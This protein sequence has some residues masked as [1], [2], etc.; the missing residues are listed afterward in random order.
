MF[1]IIIPLYN[2][3][4]TIQRTLKSVFAQNYNNFEVII[5]DDGSTD[6]GVKVITDFTND[7]RLKIFQQKNQGVSSARN[8]GVAFA[9]YPY[10]AFLDG[11]DEWLPE[12][13]E[14]MNVVLDKH[15]SVGMICCAGYVR[16]GQNEYLRLAKKYANKILLV[17]YFENPHVFTHVSATV[18]TKKA[19]DKTEG[20]P[21]GMRKNEDYALLFSVGIVEEVAYC[22]IPLSIYHGG[23]DGQA[24]TINR[25]ADYSVRDV[26]KRFNLC[27]SIFDKSKCR[28]SSLYLTFERYELRHMVIG[29]IRNN[30][31][32]RLKMFL[33]LLNH[34]VLSDFSEME[35]WLWL[36]KD[37][38][39]IAM[40]H[41]YA[42]KAIWRLNGFPVLN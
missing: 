17:D 26:A 11:D 35:V 9:K 42:S 34:L 27:R 41:I 18:I 30:D 10:I 37:M 19:F 14:T 1:S 8:N 31:Y 2:K 6:D 16:D 36:R 12:Y 21:L 4:H 29:M 38:N 28:S 33:G 23:V 20:F 7:S 13:L 39:R 32:E 25:D 15:P 40:M 22:G 3:A 24:T 5:I